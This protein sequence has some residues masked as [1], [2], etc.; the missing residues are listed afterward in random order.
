MSYVLCFRLMNDSN[1][2][3][4]MAGAGIALILL[5]LSMYGVLLANRDEALSG[6]APGL[7]RGTVM[8]NFEGASPPRANISQR[9]AVPPGQSAWDAIK[10]ALGEQRVTT[11]DFGGDLGLLI[12][13]F[14]GVLATGNRFWEFLVN[15]RPSE[16]GISGYKVKEGDTLEFRL[17]SF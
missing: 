8:V 12:T 5:A 1:R 11:Q 2:S 7:L 15:G 14:D 10:N 6:P 4:I 9:F 17:G 3:L 13:G 16:V